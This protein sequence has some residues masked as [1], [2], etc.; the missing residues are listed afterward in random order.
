MNGFIVQ[1]IGGPPI[2]PHTIIQTATKNV[3]PWKYPAIQYLVKP[4]NEATFEALW[5]NYF[6]CRMSTFRLKLSTRG[7][8]DTGSHR[9]CL[10]GPSDRLGAGPQ[11][12]AGGRPPSPHPAEPAE[13]WEIPLYMRHHSNITWQLALSPGFPHYGIPRRGKRMRS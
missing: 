12:A 10:S 3:P 2:R 13:K 7:T 6:Q 5:I 1:V 11:P 9:G 8:E 4:R